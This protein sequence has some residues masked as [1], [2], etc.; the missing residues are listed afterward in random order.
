MQKTKLRGLRTLNVTPAIISRA[1]NDYPVYQMVNPWYDKKKT[2]KQ[3][4]SLHRY[5]YYLR[6]QDLQGII[7]IAVFTPWMIQQGKTSPA[8][9]IF[10]NIDGDEYI[11]RYFHNGKEKWSTSMIGNLCSVDGYTNDFVGREI[12]CC[13][14]DSYYLNKCDKEAWI[15]PE[16]LKTLRNKTKIKGTAYECIAQ[17]QQKTKN[18]KRDEADAKVFKQWDEDLKRIPKLPQRFINWAFKENT[19][20][21]IFYNAGAKTGYCSRCQKE[22]PV[23]GQRHRKEG[24]CPNCK[25]P[26]IFLANGKKSKYLRTPIAESQI[27]QP[28]EGGYVIQIIETQRDYYAEKYPYNALQITKPKLRWDVEYKII[29]KD[30]GTISAYQEGFYKNRIYRWIPCGLYT[31]Y[32]YS[33]RTY[34]GKGEY[35]GIV[36]TAV[37]FTLRESTPK[38]V[39]FS[40]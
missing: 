2:V 3:I 23:S 38:R 19:E 28:I 18:K 25:H 7:K 27:I 16:G 35:S 36:Y 39:L 10:L 33:V 8:F 12:E 37:I 15:N 21:Y 31:P 5:G 14:W 13:Y 6:C 34:K 26:I 4:V 22:V 32:C 30:N 9:E 24:K 11:T 29:V 17:W 20:H 1:K 40:F